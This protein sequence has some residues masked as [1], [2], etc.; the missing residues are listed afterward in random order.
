L[1][2]KLATPNVKPGGQG[3][4]SKASQA[5]AAPVY[6]PAQKKVVQPKSTPLGRPVIQRALEKDPVKRKIAS[7]RQSLETVRKELGSYVKAHDDA[8]ITPENT[9]VASGVLT[10]FGE[11]KDHSEKYRAVPSGNPKHKSAE[12]DKLLFANVHGAAIV[13]LPARFHEDGKVGALKADLGQHG[14]CAEQQILIKARFDML[15]IKYWKGEVTNPW[16]HIYS[17]K[18]PC[19]KCEKAIDRF[20][21]DFRDV[22][23]F[24]EA[25]E[26]Y[27]GNFRTKWQYFP[28]NGK[29]QRIRGRLE[30]SPVSG[31]EVP[32]PKKKQEQEKQVNPYDMLEVEDEEE[33]QG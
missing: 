31:K 6:R 28:G 20:Q 7:A 3:Q 12:V 32:K 17:E 30:S 11:G 25:G 27:V 33:E 14:N 4:L 9:V 29:L 1:Q 18:T 15:K 21:Y 16:L 22:A 24:I 10:W 5:V 2:R 26:Y 23:V 19:R 8:D 13:K